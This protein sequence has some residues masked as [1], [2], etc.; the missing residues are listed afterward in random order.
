MSHSQVFAFKWLTI[1][2]LIKTKI[3]I[4][5]IACQLSTEINDREY[6]TCDQRSEGMLLI[7][8]FYIRR[9]SV[10]FFYFPGGNNIYIFFFAI[11]ARCLALTVELENF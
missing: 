6:P 9:R 1:E 5:L 11:S 10:V 7:E 2:K 8:S 3:C 4:H